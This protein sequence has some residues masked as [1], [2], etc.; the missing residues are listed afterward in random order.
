MDGLTASKRRLTYAR[1]CVLVEISAELPESFEI[2]MGGDDVRRIVVDYGWVLKFCGN[3]RK[4]GHKTI[5]YLKQS[6]SDSSAAPS[7]AERPADPESGGRRMENGEVVPQPLDTTEAVACNTTQIMVPE[8][9]NDNPIESAMDIVG[10]VVSTELALGHEENLQ[11]DSPATSLEV[12]S[13]LMP[14]SLE[15]E[16]AII[17]YVEALAD[18]TDSTAGSKLQYNEDCNAFSIL[19]VDVRDGEI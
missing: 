15:Q 10:E 2:N 6:G 9:S 19:A 4:F 13:P 17:P 11:V 18:I 7:A 8:C 14:Y 3:C 1:V 5:N 12:C 16:S